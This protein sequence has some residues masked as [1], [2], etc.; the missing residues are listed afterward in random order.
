MNRNTSSS[1]SV[2]PGTMETP[3]ERKYTD[4]PFRRKQ[5]P[6]RS[7]GARASL[8]ERAPLAT[9]GGVR[10]PTLT[11]AL[12]MGGRAAW[13]SA[14]LAAPALVVSLSRTALVWAAP[15]AAIAIARG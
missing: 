15:V 7:L 14:W 1:L 10:G 6:A 5:S 3:P 9:F 4:L 8:L 12:G 11:Q 13:R 2:R